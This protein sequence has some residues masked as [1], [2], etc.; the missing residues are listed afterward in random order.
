M[1]KRG[2]KSFEENIKVVVV[3]AAAAAAAAVVVVVAVA[4]VIIAV[5]FCHQPLSCVSKFLSIADPVLG[6][7][8]LSIIVPRLGERF[9]E[10]LEASVTQEMNSSC[11]TNPK[12]EGR[13]S[14][15]LVIILCR[16]S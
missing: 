4:V 3:V 10:G 1:F 7:K 13:V 12:G 15:S 11:E 2:T 16:R 9:L 8:S 14:S 6:V 5:N